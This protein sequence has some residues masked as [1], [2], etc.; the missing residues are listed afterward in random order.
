MYKHVEEIFTERLTELKK[1]KR[2]KTDLELVMMSEIEY[3]ISLAD[4]IKEETKAIENVKGLELNESKITRR[5]EELNRLNK[6]IDKCG[7]AVLVMWRSIN[8]D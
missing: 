2:E 1:L 5:I 7:Y 8:I 6:M 4:K 3:Y